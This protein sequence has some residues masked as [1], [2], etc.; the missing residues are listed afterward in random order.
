MTKSNPFDP[1]TLLASDAYR[2]TL[3]A[4]LQPVAGIERFQPAGFPEIGH[5]IYDSLKFASDGRADKVC[6]VDS[7]ASMANH[8]ETVCLD[9][10]F[11]AALAPELTGLPH[12]AC[13]TDNVTGGGRRLVVTTLS[14]GHR[15]ASSLF[16]DKRSVLIENGQPGTRNFGAQLMEE[17]GLVH[18][19]TRSH[20]LPQDWW[21]VF[22]TIFKYD[23][24]SL[25]HGIFFPAMGIKIPRVLTAHLEA[26]G[27]ARVPSAGVKFDKLFMT[28]SGQPIFPVDDET[29]REIRATFIIDLALLRSFGRTE[30]KDKQEVAHGLVDTQKQFLVGFALWKIGRLLRKPF[31]YRSRCDLELV[32]IRRVDDGADATLSIDDFGIKIDALLENAFSSDTREKDGRVTQVYWKADEIFR[33][34]KEKAKVSGEAQ[35]ADE[36]KEEETGESGEE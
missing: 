4:T 24:N 10:P 19:G 22:K 26:F 11:G 16:T 6:I 25:V 7:A 5:V 13:V 35:T 30:K 3:Q 34:A 14:E 21:N 15:L 8:L 17:F 18:L 1:A 31:R 12:V 36:E 20:P 2:L 27:A 23:P 33:K 28:T 9:G 29:A 32:G